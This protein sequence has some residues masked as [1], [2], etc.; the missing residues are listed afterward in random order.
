MR[1]WPVMAVALTLLM[2]LPRR[3]T[4]ISDL[5]P[6]EVLFLYKDSEYCVATDTDDLG[7]GATVEEALQ[8]L[9]QSTAGNVYLNTAEYLILTRQTIDLLPEIQGTLRPSVK[10]CLAE[11][12]IE[13]E[14]VAA[15]LNAHP[16]TRKIAE[17]E[18]ELQRLRM[19]K[20][21]YY[22]DS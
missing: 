22:L 2:L 11:G 6:V 10:I 16:P 8:D 18:P 12:P 15:Y 14:S 5:K 9:K 13:L 1:R 17:G 4:E 7:R 3:G 20:G 21:R 19:E